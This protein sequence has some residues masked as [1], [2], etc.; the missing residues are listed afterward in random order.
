[1]RVAI[2]GR[3][4]VGKSA[5]MNAILG[6]DRVIVSDIPGTTR[7]VIDTAVTFKEQPITLLDTAGIRRSGRIERGVERHSVQRARKAVERADVALV[8]MDASEPVAAQDTHIIGLAS[9]AHTGLVLVL[10][11]MDLLPPGEEAREVRR[12]VRYRARFVSGR[13]WCSSPRRAAGA[14]PLL[15]TVLEVGVQRHRRIA[16][17]GSTP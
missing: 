12:V 1:L 6:E 7:D 17:G 10:N 5:L 15:E 9:E 2:I 11:K 3:P 13:P 8:V 16:T 14:R 4:N